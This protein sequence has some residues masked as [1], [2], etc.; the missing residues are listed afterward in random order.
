MSRWFVSQSKDDWR[1]S[2][3][4]YATRDDA[5]AN[6][7]EDDSGFMNYY[8]GRETAMI[9]RV[10]GI[11]VIEHVTNVLREDFGDTIPSWLQSATKE[12]IND[13]GKRLDKAFLG[14]LISIGK[15][16]NLS[17]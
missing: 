4:A 14:W 1:F 9:P 7:P 8:V 6:P 2:D 13:L 11:K 17:K 12:Q 5:I 3:G 15:S 10:S 16:R